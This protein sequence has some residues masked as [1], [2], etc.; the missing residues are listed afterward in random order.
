MQ[1]NA[2]QESYSMCQVTRPR[3]L[4][5]LKSQLHFYYNFVTNHF[6]WLQQKN[7]GPADFRQP[8]Q[9]KG[10]VPCGMFWFVLG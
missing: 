9:E 3:L 2:D 7:A 10:L 1:S 5:Q 6:R 8:C 4:G